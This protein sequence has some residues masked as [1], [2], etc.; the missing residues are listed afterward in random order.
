MARKILGGGPRRTET[1]AQQHARRIRLVASGEPLPPDQQSAIPEEQQV[2][3]PE[4]GWSTGHLLTE[5]PLAR[6]RPH[7]MDGAQ[8]FAATSKNLLA[9]ILGKLGLH[10]QQFSNFRVSVAIRDQVVFPYNPLRAYVIVVNTGPATMFAAFGRAAN[11]ATGVP[12]V[13]GGNYEP[14]LGFV[15]SLHVSSTVAGSAVIVEG[16]YTFAGARAEGE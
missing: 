2:Y 1:P 16:F 13:V 12:I 8:G 7:P 6:R 11:A 15:N 5:D 3:L 10:G 9:M 4:V 14:I